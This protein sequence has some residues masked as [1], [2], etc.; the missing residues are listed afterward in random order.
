[1]AKPRQVQKREPD[2]A[3]SALAAAVRAY[4]SEK[5]N[6]APDMVMRRVEF[7]RMKAALA[8]WDKEWTG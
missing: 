3:S 6:P 4:I 1:M 8:G 7:G 5:E 2:Y